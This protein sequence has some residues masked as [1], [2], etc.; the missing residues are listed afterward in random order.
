MYPCKTLGFTDT[1][2]VLVVEAFVDLFSKLP[3]MEEK[4]CGYFTLRDYSSNRVILTR[5]IGICPSDKWQRYHDL[6]LEKGDRLFRNA[7]HLSSRESRDHEKSQ[8]G[9]A[10]SAE[11][12]SLSF[13]GLPELGDEAVMLCAARMLGWI[14]DEAVAVILKRNHGNIFYQQLLEVSEKHGTS[15]E[16]GIG[17]GGGIG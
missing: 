11:S 7:D 1:E 5:Q 4:N 14:S 13:S 3:G 10:I 16:K 15:S 6:S 17:V 12:L 2:I 9:G 8:Y